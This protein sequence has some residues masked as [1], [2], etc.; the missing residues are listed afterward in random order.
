MNEDVITYA[1]T[2]YVKSAREPD[3][4]PLVLNKSSVVNMK[5]PEGEYTAYLYKLCSRYILYIS[6]VTIVTY[7]SL[8]SIPH[9]E[10][11][12][13]ISVSV[14]YELT[15]SLTPQLDIQITW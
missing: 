15:E 11:R 5:L 3:G 10:F 8:L 13:S 4:Y 9:C 1:F 7:C 12:L 14:L 6:C 2:E